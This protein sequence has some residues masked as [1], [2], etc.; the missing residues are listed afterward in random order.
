[1]DTLEDEREFDTSEI[2]QKVT[3]PDSNRK[4]VKEIAKYA[5]EH[6]RIYGHFPKTLI[7]GAND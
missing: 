5:Q 4:I 1:M 2:K 6:E 3:S 7:F